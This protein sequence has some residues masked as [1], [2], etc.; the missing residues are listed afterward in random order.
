[1]N[2]L[3]YMNLALALAEDALTT[4]DVPVGCVIVDGAGAVVGRG[5]NRREAVQD[6]TAHAEIEALRQASQALGRWH[7]DDCTLYVTLEPCPMCAGAIWNARVGR[8]VFGASDERAGCC[9]SRLHLGTE[10]FLPAPKMQAGVLEEQCTALLQRFFRSL[11][12]KA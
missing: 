7:L 6:A 2:D 5:Q 8:V 9:G 12:G 3:E 11:R 10:G 1:M 4:G